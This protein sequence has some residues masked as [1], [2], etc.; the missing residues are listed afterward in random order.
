MCTSFCGAE[1]NFSLT[2]ILEAVQVLL[3]Y[4]TS[5]APGSPVASAKDDE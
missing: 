2:S 4:P 1:A 5:Q 3:G